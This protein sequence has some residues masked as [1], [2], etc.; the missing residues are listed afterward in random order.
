MRVGTYLYKAK[1]RGVREKHVGHYSISTVDLQTSA[2][3]KQGRSVQ[4]GVNKHCLAE[5]T[6]LF[7]LLGASRE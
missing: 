7:I 5:D 3:H 1:R 6:K 4:L 2:S